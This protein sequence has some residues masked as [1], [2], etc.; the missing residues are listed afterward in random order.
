MFNGMTPTQLQDILTA[1]EPVE[2]KGL[3]L[4]RRR[5]PHSGRRPQVPGVIGASSWFPADISPRVLAEAATEMMDYMQG[6][7]RAMQNLKKLPAVPLAAP[8]EEWPL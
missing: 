7:E 5:R 4:L 3:A 8:V 1:V 2:L 6:C